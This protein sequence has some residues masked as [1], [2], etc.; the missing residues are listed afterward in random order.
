MATGRTSET[1]H[2][3]LYLSFSWLCFPESPALCQYWFL[4]VAAIT[5]HGALSL[6]WCGCSPGSSA[7]SNLDQAKSEGWLARG[8][9]R[10]PCCPIQR[11]VIS[12]H[13]SWQPPM[14]AACQMCLS[15]V[16][17]FSLPGWAGWSRRAAGWPCGRESLS[18][19]PRLEAASS[20]GARRWL[21]GPSLFLR[22]SSL[23]PPHPAPSDLLGANCNCLWEQ[24][25]PVPESVGTYTSGLF[26]LGVRD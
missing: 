21:C 3:G 17:P 23:F 18:F 8:C 7:P 19:Q 9:G 1:N 22:S 11:S 12:P 15:A 13:R 10:A 6:H 24:T 5:P 14:G 25:A 4:A 16:Q 20:G 26:S 2:T